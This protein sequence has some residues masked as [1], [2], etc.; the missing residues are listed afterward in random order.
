[1]KKTVALIFG[2]EGIEHEISERSAYTLYTFID[3]NLYTPL[4]IG[5]KRDGKMYAFLGAPEKIECGEWKN[6][7]ELFPIYFTHKG[8]V[9]EKETVPIDL[10]IISL[11]GDYGEDGVIQGALSAAHIDYV[12]A[13]VYASAICQDKSYTKA[14]ASILSVPTASSLIL[15]TPD[16][17]LAKKEAEKVLSYPMFLKPARLG[18]SFGAHPVLTGDDFQ[19]AYLD[20]YK[21]SKRVL[22]EEKIDTK[23]ELEIAYLG[24]EKEEYAVGRVNSLGAFYDFDTKYQKGSNTEPI[25]N[26]DPYSLLTIEYSERLRSYIG[27]FDLCRFDFLVSNEGKVYFNEINTLPG[28]TKTSLYPLLTE[29]MGHSRGEF[30]NLLIKKHLLRDR[31]IR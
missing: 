3:K 27:I 12:G 14:I 13:D 5:I 30:I 16:A 2:G 28:M 20:A 8:I 19:K 10:A 29:K 22:I 18:S 1:M 26:D 15:D 4:P 23:F 21:K 6:D 9:K 7:T 11:H 25:P 31:D 24:L 17:A